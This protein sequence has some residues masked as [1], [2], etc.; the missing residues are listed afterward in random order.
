MSQCFTAMMLHLL[1][2]AQKTVLTTENN[3]RLTVL[4]ATNSFTKTVLSAKDNSLQI[5][6]LPRKIFQGNRIGKN[7]N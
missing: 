6:I 5:G 4:S 7:I 3:L 1:V 2:F